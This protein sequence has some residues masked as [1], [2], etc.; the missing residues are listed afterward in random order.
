MSKLIK[1]FTAEV[2]HGDGRRQK[3]APFKRYIGIIDGVIP[4]GDDWIGIRVDGRIITGMRSELVVKH[5]EKNLGREMEYTLYCPGRKEFVAS[6][7]D[8]WTQ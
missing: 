2:I 1:E 6:N 8:N 5:I 3:N 4:K 7:F